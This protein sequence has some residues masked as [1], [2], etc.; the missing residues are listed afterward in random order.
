MKKYIIISGMDL[1]DTNR[2]T[3][4]LGYGAISFLQEKRYL[5]PNNCI[6]EI[7]PCIKFWKYT[8]SEEVL[9][10]QGLEILKKTIYVPSLLFKLVVNFGIVLPFSNLSKVINKIKLVACINGGDGF[11][12]IYNTHTFQYRLTETRI[13]MKRG[14]P[15]IQLPQ[16]IGPFNDLHNF[17]TAIGILKYSSKVYVR[18]NKFSEILRE[19]NIDFELT[20]DLSAYMQPESFNIEIKPNSI[21][22]NISG[23]CYSN[24][25]RALKGQFNL[26][27]VL[28][29]KIIKYFN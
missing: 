20:K 13:A 18:D 23:L 15:V 16:T 29:D 11:S 28:I 7:K 4:A 10:I 17:Q 27:P 6:L 22:L 14:I 12:D 21:G 2:G 1:Y 26:Y 19:N 25:F 5:S 8:D 24:K 9:R 3:A